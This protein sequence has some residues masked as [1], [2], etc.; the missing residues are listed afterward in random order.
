MHYTWH[1]HL[2]LDTLKASQAYAF[3]ESGV[4]V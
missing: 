2:Q 1:S 3:M 4:P